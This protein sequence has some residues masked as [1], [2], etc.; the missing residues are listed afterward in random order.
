MP[1]RENTKVLL[2]DHQRA[3]EKFRALVCASD[4]SLIGTLEAAAILIKRASTE[5]ENARQAV[6]EHWM[7]SSADQRPVPAKP[8]RSEG[9]EL[10]KRT[11]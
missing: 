1:V 2:D 9:D 10:A 3:V 8:I 7:L 11:A 4:A 5:C 6:L